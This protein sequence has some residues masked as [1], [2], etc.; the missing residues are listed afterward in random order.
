M[1][2]LFSDKENLHE[3][4]AD[5]TCEISIK[6]KLIEEL[7]NSQKRLHAMRSQYEEKLI[8]LQDKIRTTEVERDKVLSSMGK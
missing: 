3:D 6:E 1:S 7:E 4:L 5:L 8:L 2:V